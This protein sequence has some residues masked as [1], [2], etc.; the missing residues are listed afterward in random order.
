M[1]LGFDLYSH[2][3]GPYHSMLARVTCFPC[4][5]INLVRHT[6]RLHLHESRRSQ[7]HEP[8][9]LIHDYCAAQFPFLQQ[10]YSRALENASRTCQRLRAEATNLARL[11][12][13]T[14]QVSGTHCAAIEI[15]RSTV[16]CLNNVIQAIETGS[17]VS[18]TLL[19]GELTVRRAL[20]TKLFD[21]RA[22]AIV[23]ALASETAEN[24]N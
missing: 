2:L 22:E 3:S 18:R 17:D 23:A 24:I 9:I 10:Q 13:C 8:N 11:P 6:A 19:L 12:S 5:E 4:R 15:Y 20:T 14:V 16:Q 21:R 1:I 7:R